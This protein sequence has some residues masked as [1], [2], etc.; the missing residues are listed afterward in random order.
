MKGDGFR[1]KINACSNKVNIYY[2]FYMGEGKMLCDMSEAE[3]AMLREES[4]ERRRKYAIA[5]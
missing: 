5:G 4:L 3:I 2:L 1:W